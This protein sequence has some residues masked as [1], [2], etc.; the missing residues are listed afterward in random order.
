MDR[1]IMV[2]HR[3]LSLASILCVAL[4]GLAGCV[5]VPDEV[6]LSPAPGVA[7]AAPAPGLTS[8]C[9]EGQATIGRL[10]GHVFEL[11]VETRHM[12]DFGAT[13]H[14]GA[15]C[16]DRLAISERRGPP[17][18]PGV[19]GRYEW[20]GVDLQGAFLVEQPGV[21]RFRL[22]SDDGARLVIDGALVV[23]NDGYHAVR[24]REAAVALGPGPHTIAVPYWQGP[25]PMML[26]LEVARPGGPWEVLR[27]DR[28][29]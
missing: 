14:A 1:V 13:P 12:P 18:F 5:E 25:G 10:Q 9:I 23:E 3:V 27:V 2:P 16:L 28:P 21:F 4:A 11:P 22:T 7:P 20:F 24:S 17:G 19:R 6:V 8:G 26:V 15:I 29:L